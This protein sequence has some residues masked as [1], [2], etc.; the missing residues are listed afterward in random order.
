M[1]CHG[2]ESNPISDNVPKWTASQNVE[3]V[4][5]FAVIILELVAGLGFEPRMAMA[6]ETTLVTGPSP[7]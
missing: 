3:R 6:Y 1:S 7:R 5:W 4:K 2:R